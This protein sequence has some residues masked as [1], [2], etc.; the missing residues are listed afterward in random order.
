MCKISIIVPIHDVEKYLLR[1][2]DSL[3]AQ[4]CRDFEAILIDD[5]SPDRC[6]RICDEYAAG[7]ARFIVL[8]QENRGVSAA[9]NAGLEIARGEYIGFVDPDD[10]T[11]PRMFAAMVEKGAE[12]GAE[13]ICCNW[14]TVRTDGTSAVHPLAQPL[15]ERMT[16]EEF[17][18]HV[19]D[20]PRS[21]GGTVWNKV[22]KR[23]AVRHMFQPDAVVCEDCLFLIGNLPFVRDAAFID[24][25]F[26]KYCMRADSITRVDPGKLALGL[27]IRRRLIDLVAPM[28][29]QT[30]QAAEK[31]YLDSCRGVLNRVTQERL[32]GP[33][34]LAKTEYGS[35]LRENIRGI[36]KNREIGWKNKLL[37]FRD[38]MRRMG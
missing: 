6:G 33:C 27:P 20:I 14:E 5:G 26:Y 35:Y 8:H 15:P 13:L 30:A 4:T 29:E 1:C 37:Y 7:D 23:E 17:A 16:A 36:M 22:F 21:L 18:R 34:R 38:Y 10:Y 24:A 28:G 32:A 12:T 19:F 2:L 9:R 3:A 25:P 11:D 31:Y